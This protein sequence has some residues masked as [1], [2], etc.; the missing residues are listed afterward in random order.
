MPSMY[1]T[2]GTQQRNLSHRRPRQSTALLAAIAALSGVPSAA[3]AGD[4][5][6][7]AAMRKDWLGRWS[8]NI[9]ADEAHNHYCASE[10]GEEVGWL[11][12]PFLNGFYYGYLATGDPVWVDRFV[13][14]A[15]AWIQ[16]AV[17]EPDGFLGWPKRNDA[18][19]DLY[20]DSLLGETMGLRPTVL[21][22][23]AILKSPALKEKYG[24]KARGYIAL[25]ERTFE[26]WNSRGCWRDLKDGGG[27]WVVPAFGLDAD[28][29]HWTAGY[30]KSFT[31]GFTNPDNKEN[32]IAT[33]MLAM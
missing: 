24:D 27:V 25:A 4:G 8:A 19:G 13:T 23:D 33:W 10:T 12:S 32:I 15:D 9:V 5:G 16:R 30:D 18:G 7:D 11:I 20:T 14:C 2:P 17:K 28:G 1:I 29:T 6:M 26:K 21:M 31:D 3:L 22:A